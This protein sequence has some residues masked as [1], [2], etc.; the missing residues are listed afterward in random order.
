[1]LL[2]LRL[3]PGSCGLGG[4]APVM[5]LVPETLLVLARSMARTTVGVVG[6]EA[7]LMWLRDRDVARLRLFAS[8]LM[9][10]GCL[11]TL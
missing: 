8:N 3:V 1:V 6:M 5:A 4:T 10:L 7:G 9:A 11:M 2:V